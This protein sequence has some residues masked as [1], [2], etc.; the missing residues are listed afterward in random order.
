V[1]ALLIGYGNTLRH[2]DGAGHAVA[3][4]VRDF[5]IPGVEVVTSHQLLPEHSEIVS[6]APLVVF[7]DATF[8]DADAV[9]AR[10]VDPC[11]APDLWGHA[12]DPGALLAM[13]ERLYSRRPD[14]WL[15]TVPGVDFRMGEGLSQVAAEGVHTAALATLKIFR[16][17]GVC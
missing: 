12:C 7:A 8:G 5:D 11:H 17:N 6:Q 15:V 1:K 16:E 4:A 13:A 3:R 10:R 14:G 2:D 9:C